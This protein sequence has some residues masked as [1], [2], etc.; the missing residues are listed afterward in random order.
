[1]LRK[2]VIVESIGLYLGLC[3]QLLSYKRKDNFKVKENGIKRCTILSFLYFFL[4]KSDML[5]GGIK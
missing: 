3:D 2:L 5:F 1:M 4:K